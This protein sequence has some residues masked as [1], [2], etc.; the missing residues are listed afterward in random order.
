MG[1]VGDQLTEHLHPLAGPYLFVGAGLSRRY[2]GLGDWNGLLA[3]FANFT[4]HQFDYYRGATGDDQP[5][6]A[7]SIADAF[8]DKWWEDPQFKESVSA[9]S[10]SVDSR[11]S[12]LKYEVAQY[13]RE[14][15]ENLVLPT[16]LEDEFD[17]LTSAVVDGVI[18]TNFDRLLE[19]AFPDFRTFIGQD[20]LLFSDTQGIAEMYYI[21]GSDKR[22]ESLVLTTADYEDYNARNAYLAAKLATIFVEHPVIFLGY[23][24]SDK[25]IQKLLESLIAGLRPENVSKLQD[26]LIFIEW[27][28]DEE[29]EIASTVMNVGGVTLPII[30]ATVPDF[31]EVFEVLGQRERA[32][33]ARILRVLKEQVFELVR[34]NDPNG[35][36]VA[37]SDID[38]DKDAENL[39]VV[40]G[41]AAKMTAVGLVGLTRWDIVD[42][43]LESP[44]RALP[45][46]LMVSKALPKQAS[47]TYVPTFKYIVGAGL[48]AS[49]AWIPKVTVNSAVKKRG[50]KYASAFSALKPTSTLKTISELESARGFEWVFTNALRLPSFTD[51]VDGLLEFLVRHK[52]KRERKWSVQYAK[53]AVAYDWMRYGRATT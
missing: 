41:V 37:M 45:C 47:P 16:E 22:P 39:D 34:S 44:D 6:I 49:G 52:A 30:R 10:T 11:D 33:P 38:S 15:I 51:D 46:D 9:W 31:T 5:A 23:S 17:L 8:Y 42:D 43:V 13:T 48:W 19:K 3:H 1:K 12:P 35:R 21:H 20:E 28:P 14:A 25:N 32:L 29:A 50:D 53:A 40:F 27:I 24:L 36:L 26:R 7:S 18:T 2:A 4:D